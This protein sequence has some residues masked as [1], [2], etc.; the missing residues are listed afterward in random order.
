MQLGIYAHPWDLDALGAHGGLARLADLGFSE[1][2]LAVSYHAGRWLTPWQPGGKVRFLEDGTVHFR[3]EADYGLLRPQ[4]SSE[5]RDGEPSPLERLCAEAPRHGLRAR[6][7]A[8]LTHNTRLGELHPDCCVQNA[9][10]D[11]YSYSLCHANPHVQRY[12]RAMVQDLRAHQ[13]LHAIELEAIASLGHRHSSHHDKNSF[14]TDAFVD[15]LMSACFCD[16]CTDA[17]AA[18]KVESA[19]LGR[20]AI[21]ALRHKVRALLDAHFEQD[22]MAAAGKKATPQQLVERLRAE[23]GQAAL[24]MLGART[25]SLMKLLM[26]LQEAAAAGAALCAQTNHDALRGNAA[27][28]FPIVGGLVQECAMTVYGEKAAEVE[29]ALPHLVAA[30]GDGILPT[31]PAGQQPALRLCLHPRAPQY[32]SDDDL[33]RVRDLCAQ[34]GIAAVSIYHLGLLP[35]RTIE[36]VAKAWSA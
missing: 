1:V 9:Y 26:P 21:E 19:P 11:A 5:V 22:C 10:G 36:R 7:W 24:A 23:L 20:D 16:A 27:L 25:L 8:V 3:P 30:R 6:A 13:G 14:P 28:P 17:M 2:A 32:Q 18:T 4:Q 15:V 12:A 34:N 35:W 31:R 33:R 29:A